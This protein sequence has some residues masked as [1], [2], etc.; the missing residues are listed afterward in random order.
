MYGFQKLKCFTEV[1]SILYIAPVNSFLLISL[2][3]L[4]NQDIG[5]VNIAKY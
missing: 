4:L 3:A 5:E 1:L 2:V